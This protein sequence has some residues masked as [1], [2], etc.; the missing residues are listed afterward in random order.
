MARA[1]GMA[2][3]ASRGRQCFNRCPSDFLDRLGNAYSSMMSRGSRVDFKFA[4][5]QHAL[6]SATWN[7]GQTTFS[8]TKQCQGESTEHR[9]VSQNCI[10]STSSRSARLAYLRRTPTHFTNSALLDHSLAIWHSNRAAPLSEA[11][12]PWTL[13]THRHLSTH[14]TSLPR[15]LS[16]HNFP[17]VLLQ[18]C[19]SYGRKLRDHLPYPCR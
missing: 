19:R 9:K 8:S 13:D 15:C 2:S 4:R 12:V 14:L 1:L 16:Q 18:H 7:S 11:A 6:V 17:I 3:S 5:Q 10:N